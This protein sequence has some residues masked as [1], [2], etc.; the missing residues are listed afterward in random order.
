MTTT[1]VTTA[2]T[3]ALTIDHT[4]TISRMSIVTFA[5]KGSLM[6]TSMTMTGIMTEIFTTTFIN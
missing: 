2:T 5:P 1:H 3:S 6:T 4:T